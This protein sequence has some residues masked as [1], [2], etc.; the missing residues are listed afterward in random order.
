MK[1]TLIAVIVIAVALVAVPTLV[2]LAQ[3]D[4]S[5]PTTVTCPNDGDHQA[6][7]NQ[8]AATMGMGQ[9]DMDQMDMNQ[10]DMNQM[11]MDRDDSHMNADADG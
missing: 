7:H 3:S 4:Q 1:R 5:E 9:M 10:M 6:M 8:M 2:A 11:D